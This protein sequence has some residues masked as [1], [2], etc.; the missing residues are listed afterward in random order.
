VPEGISGNELGQL[1]RENGLVNSPR[2]MTAYL[3][4]TKSAVEIEPGPHVL[5]DALSPRRLL[6]RLARVPSRPALRV[7]FPEGYNHA[8][9]AQRLEQ[10]EVCA[11][12]SFQH[13]VVDRKLLSSLGIEGPS[14]EGYLFPA[15]YE[16]AVDS[17]PKLVIGALARETDKRLKK[18]E[19]QHRVAFDRLRR[20]YGFGRH[21][22]LT[23]ASIVEKEAAHPDERKTIASVFYNRLSDPQFRP[24]KTLQ[25]DPTAAYGCLIAAAE[26]PSCRDYAGRVTPQMLKDQR[27]PYNTYRRAGLPPGPIA[28]PGEASIVA[29]LEP[30][31][32]DYLFFV[33]R[34]DGRHT[35]SRTF[36]EHNDAIRQRRQQVEK[37]RDQP[38]LDEQ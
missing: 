33:S 27:N 3:L 32:T 15:T 37:L 11:A 36:S 16:F 2:L 8:Q 22:L 21:E 10:S 34:G 28:N 6:Q 25:S 19:N 13:A 7:T 4:L 26:I 30:A 18:L 12:K 5:N 14:A 29:A 1:L 9:I 35:F 38:E 23:F 24:Q 20:D 17:D 31:S